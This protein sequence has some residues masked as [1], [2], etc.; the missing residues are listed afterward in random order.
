MPFTTTPSIPLGFV[1]VPTNVGP[2][3]VAPH[4]ASDA[5]PS[6]PI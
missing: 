2:A 6:G 5:A 4:T 3:S 1:V